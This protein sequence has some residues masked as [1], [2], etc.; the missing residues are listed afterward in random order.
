M[1]CHVYQIM[2]KNKRKKNK[3]KREKKENKTK[4]KKR[5]KRTHP[6]YCEDTYSVRYS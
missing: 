5:K 3:I 4:Q 2:H 1:K 6:V